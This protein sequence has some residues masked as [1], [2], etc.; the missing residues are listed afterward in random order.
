M[1]NI[2]YF[3]IPSDNVERARKFYSTV[4]GWDIKKSTMPGTPPDYF[5]IMTGAAQTRNNMSTLNSGGLSK[6]MQ[7]KQPITNYIEVDNIEET[8]EKVK[9]LGG[10]HVA[11]ILTIPTVGRIAFIFDSEENFIGIWEPEKK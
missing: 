8:L 2:A 11:E 4:F 10:K 7:P 5:E 1:G 6:R 9:D 3:E